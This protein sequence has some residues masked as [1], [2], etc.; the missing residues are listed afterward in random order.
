MGIIACVEITTTTP[1]SLPTGAPASTNIPSTSGTPSSPT[2][3][4]SYPT[5]TAPQSTIE[6]APQIGT[7]STTGSSFPVGT[8]TTG[9]SS[10]TGI[11]TP[12]T[13]VPLSTAGASSPAAP[14]SLSTATPSSTT[15]ALPPTTTTMNYCEEENGMNQPL[16]IQP[17]QLTSNQP[18]NE[19]TGNI[20]PTSTTPGL[21]FPS[22]NPLINITLIQ[23]ATLTIIYLPTD[24]PNQQTN[25][26]QF[27]VIFAYPNG[28]TREFTS[29]T[30]STSGATT[31]TPST[32]VPSEPTTT[33][34]GLV[35]PSGV[36]PQVDLPSNFQVPSGTVLMITIT[37]TQ[38]FASP[39]GVSRP[40]LCNIQI[41]RASLLCSPYNALC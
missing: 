32:G 10:S 20:N 1:S 6:A 7:T 18:Y 2:A 14:P 39:Y 19:A 13:S 37:S 35:P 3:V 28:T 17:N 33:S 15:T 36:S 34:S 22:M 30:P 29:Q 4:T 31:T 8:S 26:Q 16:T 41:E 21:D 9:Q 11:P 38:N 23:P 12:T 24:R 5:T 27:E 40:S 25:V